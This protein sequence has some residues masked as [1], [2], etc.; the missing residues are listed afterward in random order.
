MFQL[1]ELPMALRILARQPM[2]AWAAIT[3]MTLA[4]AAV[5]AVF[6][7]LN[8]VLLTPLPYREPDRVALLRADL[9]GYE[10][11]PLLTS[12]EFAALRDR[13]D[14]FDGAAAIVEAN[15]SLTTPGD[16]SR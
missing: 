11:E 14:L 1:R 6:S 7:V 15:G 8:G 4:V 3:V 16:R 2:Y 9:Q 10:Q 5:T 12:M 13:T